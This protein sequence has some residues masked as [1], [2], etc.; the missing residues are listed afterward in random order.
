MMIQSMLRRRVYDLVRRFP[1]LRRFQGKLGLG[2]WLAPSQ[3]RERITI[4]G[5]IVI[6]LDF[7]F[8]SCRAVYFVCDPSSSAE[9]I[10]LRRLVQPTDCMVDVGA[11]FGYVSL[12]AAKYARHVFAFEPSPNTFAYLQHN[13]ELNPQL[14]HKVTSRMVGLSAQAGTLTLYRSPVDAG[15]ASLHPLEQTMTV[16]ESV[17][18]DT[19]DHLL[20]HETVGWLKIDVEGAELDVLRG[21]EQLIRRDRP[22]VLIELF[23]PHQ[24]RFGYRCQ[25]ILDFFVERQYEGRWIHQ[26]LA[27]LTVSLVPVNVAQLISTGNIENAL[28]VPTE[29]ATQIFAQAVKA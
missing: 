17:N 7:S 18:V 11:N 14:A 29:H 28:F 16:Q 13:L 23:E 5:D 27:S 21:G 4:D 3:T 25:D 15:T 9:T 20:A 19:L 2:R 1:F 8:A 6:E 24:Q 10:L 12:V 22:N 26:D